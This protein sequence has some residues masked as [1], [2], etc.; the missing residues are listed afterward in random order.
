M[1]RKTTCITCDDAKAVCRCWHYCCCFPAVA[2]R[3]K[4]KHLGARLKMISNEQLARRLDA[5]ERRLNADRATGT[6]PTGISLLC[7]VIEGGL[8]SISGE[9]LFAMA[10]AHQW[11]RSEGEGLDAFADRA[12]AGAREAKEALLIIGGLPRTQEQQDVAMVAFDA[13]LE[14]DDGIPPIWTGP[15]PSSRLG[16]VDR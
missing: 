3:A 11:I 15:Q 10:G 13:W 14:T 9:P 7:V 6:L 8:P 12:R 16:F 1:H 5:L 4:P 2:S